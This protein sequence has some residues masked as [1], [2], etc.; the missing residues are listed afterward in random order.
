[1]IQRQLKLKL[2]PAQER[3]R[4]V[5][6]EA[7]RAAFNAAR[8]GR[9][10]KRKSPVSADTRALLSAAVKGERNGRYNPNRDVVKARLKAQRFMRDCLRRLLVNKTSSS[11]EMLGYSKD[12]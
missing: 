2:R 4:Y 8:F 10:W 3:Q 12:E 7:H 11:S 5:W 9:H 1:M 6:T